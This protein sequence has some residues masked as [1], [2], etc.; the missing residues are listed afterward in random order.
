[1]K[2]NEKRSGFLKMLTMALLL[3]GLFI[4]CNDEDDPKPDTISAPTVN[5]ATDIT[6][7]SF[8]VSW[9]QVTGAEKY[10][11]DVSTNANFSTTLTGYNKKEVTETNASISG[12]TAKTKYYYRVFT[13]KGTTVSTASSV[14]DA[15]TIE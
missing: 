8:K 13:K 1:M 2:M 15:T 7:T 6:A 10:L 5:A 12:L 11:L 3:T 14:K 4:A 9:S